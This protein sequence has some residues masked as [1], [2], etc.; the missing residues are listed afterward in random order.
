MYIP[1]RPR[2]FRGPFAN[3]HTRQEERGAAHQKRAKNEVTKCV[4]PN[5]NVHAC[6]SKPGTSIGLLNGQGALVADAVGLP[7][8]PPPDLVGVDGRL[9]G[10]L[11][12]VE[13]IESIVGQDAVA[14]ERPARRAH[15]GRGPAVRDRE[16]HRLRLVRDDVR[17]LEARRRRVDGQEGEPVAAAGHAGPRHHERLRVGFVLD[18]PDVGRRVGVEEP[19]GLQVVEV[20]AAAAD[21]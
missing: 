21:G 11:A 8:T 4:S 13:Q 18:L 1:P 7:C 17:L 3:A 5:R 15:A 10:V 20:E 19:Q 12:R 14:V 16:A 6:T 2:F 9:V